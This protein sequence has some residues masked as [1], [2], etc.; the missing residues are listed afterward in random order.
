MTQQAE[1]PLD[2]KTPANGEKKLETPPVEAAPK[3]AQQII[4]VSD[5]EQEVTEPS[6]ALSAFASETAFKAG[7]RMARAMSTSSLVPKE[8]QGEQ[9]IPNVLIAM[10]LANRI[11]ASVLMVMQSL[12]IILGRP[13]WR[14]TFL[15]AT[16]NASNRFTP[17][18]FRWTGKEGSDEWGC[19]CVAQDR[20]SKEECL[21]ALITIGL[22]K[23]EGWTSKNGS[24]W[25]TMPEQMLMYRAASFWTRIYAPELSLGMQTREEVIDTYG[26]VREDV[27]LPAGVAPGSPAALEQALRSAGVTQ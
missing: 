11:G 13:S 10:E 4:P 19:R 7:Y 14:A 26:E 5:I 27:S 15:I 8:Y 1:I 23:A 6:R 12:D 16:V 17:L 3:P 9:N 18:R 2:Q 24:K 25:K 20:D 22:A 21:G